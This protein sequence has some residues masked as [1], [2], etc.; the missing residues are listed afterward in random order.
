MTVAIRSPEGV[1]DD[2][3]KRYRPLLGQMTVGDCAFAACRVL[4]QGRRADHPRDCYT[5]VDAGG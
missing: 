4:S 5:A 3:P 1:G 2:A